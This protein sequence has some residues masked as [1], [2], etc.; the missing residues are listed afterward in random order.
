MEYWASGNVGTCS[1]N[2]RSRK[3]F[4]LQHRYDGLGKHSVQDWR[5][6]WGCAPSIRELGRAWRGV[7]HLD[8]FVCQSCARIQLFADRLTRDSLGRRVR[9][10]SE[11]F[12]IPIQLS[13][14]LS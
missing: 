4:I 9:V 5:S 8:A 1:P 13:T 6:K 12:S 3:V 11:K 2:R 7:L 14:A 10:A